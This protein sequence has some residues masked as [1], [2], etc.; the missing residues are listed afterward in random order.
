[1]SASVDTNVRA[2]S[3]SKAERPR[4]TDAP[5]THSARIYVVCSPRPRVGKT[6]LARLLTEFLEMETAPVVAYDL[7]TDGKKLADFLPDSTRVAQIGDTK[8]QIGLFDHLVGDPKASKVVD[9]GHRQFGEFF[10]V[11][12][13]IGFFAEACRCSIEPVVLFLVDADK[14][15]AKA[16][17]GL[18]QRFPEATLVPVLNDA[19]SKGHQ[20]RDAFPFA[21]ASAVPLKIPQLSTAAKALI[22]K[23]PFSFAGFRKAPESVPAE[24]RDEL[25]SW[26][27]RVLLE[28]RELELRLLL[29]E[30]KPSLQ[31]QL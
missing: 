31:F 28:F 18:H 8:G 24:Q 26:M 6:L 20:H 3:P 25:Q 19:V 2:D 17:S 4:K 12:E 23:P 5:I 15:S 14:A 13:K 30:L 7:D 22:D 1:M 27:K 21:A 16:Y 9:P 11:A 29:E 10:A